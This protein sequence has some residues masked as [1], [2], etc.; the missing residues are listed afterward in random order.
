MQC[1]SLERMITDGKQRQQNERK[2]RL[3]PVVIKLYTRV[4]SWLICCCWIQSL[5]TWTLGS[6]D[7]PDPPCS[8][9]TWSPC[10]WVS[11]RP[12]DAIR[13]T[14]VSYKSAGSDHHYHWPVFSNRIKPSCV[15]SC[16]LCL[17][18]IVKEYTNCHT[19]FTS[20]FVVFNYFSQKHPV[21]IGKYLNAS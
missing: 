15:S 20:V 8:C 2:Y 18:C 13:V 12:R 21:K 11:W 10:N 14:C 17:F 6:T 3:V 1:F 9:D 5:E 7:A 19:Y 4:R 16:M